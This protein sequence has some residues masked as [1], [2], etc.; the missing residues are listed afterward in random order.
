LRSPTLAATCA[1]IIFGRP[2]VAHV[3]RGGLLGDIRVLSEAPLGKA[4]LCLFRRAVDRFV[5]VSR[6][7]RQELLDAGIPA[8]KIVLIPYGVDTGRFRP[9]N[10]DERGALRTHL[11]LQGRNVVLVVARLV[12]EKRFDRLLAAWPFVKA[13]VPAAVLVIVGDGPERTKLQR[14]ATG[15]DGVRFVG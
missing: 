6:E 13:G 14:Q 9:A 7:T 15:M 10:G 1:G 2:V 12:P 3:L 5:A 8:R 4:R 11:D